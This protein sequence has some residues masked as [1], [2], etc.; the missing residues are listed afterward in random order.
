MQKMAE[1]L[2]TPYYEA[3]NILLDDRYTTTFQ[4]SR[5]I[6]AA[7]RVKKCNCTLKAVKSAL[8]KAGDDCDDKIAEHVVKSSQ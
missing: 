8:L 5:P 3:A 7:C 1:E 6:N 2:G 4:A